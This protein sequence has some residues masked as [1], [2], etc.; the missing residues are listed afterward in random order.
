MN[1]SKTPRSP[2]I[3]YAV[4]R[5]DR[6]SRLTAVSA[7]LA[8]ISLVL[9]L[10]P[11][12]DLIVGIRLPI[13]FRWTFPLLGSPLAAMIGTMTGVGAWLNEPR[14]KRGGAFC[15]L[16]A[17]AAIVLLLIS[18]ACAYLCLRPSGQARSHFHAGP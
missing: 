4:P 6:R 18:V 10:M 17:N 13:I 9:L 8:V 15:A 14:G 3:G 2:I 5:A 12:V 16:L 11:L 7:C 1:S